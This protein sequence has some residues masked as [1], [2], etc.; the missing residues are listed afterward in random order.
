MPPQ[1]GRLDTPFEVQAYTETADAV[2]GT[3]KAWSTRGIVWAEWWAVKGEERAMAATTV[4]RVTHRARIWPFPGIAA[5]THRLRQGS[6][7]FNITFVDERPSDCVLD[8]LEVVGREA[9]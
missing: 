3:V 8:C 6:R 4:A 2:G 1:V 5:G 9:Q 7:T